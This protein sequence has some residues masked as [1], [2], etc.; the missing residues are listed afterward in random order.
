MKDELKRPL[1][2][3]VTPGLSKLTGDKEETERYFEGIFKYI[4]DNFSYDKHQNTGVFILGTAGMRLLDDK[5]RDIIIE[6][7]T[8]LFKS[9]YNFVKVKTAVISGADEGMFTW[10]T[11]NSRLRLFSAGE[12]MST[13]GIIEMGGASVQVTYR[14]TK[15]LKDTIRRRLGVSE[16]QTKFPELIVKPLL[17]RDKEPYEL[18][19]TTFLGLGGNSARDAY[20][21]LLIS[22]YLRDLNEETSKHLNRNTF[23]MFKSSAKSRRKKSRDIFDPNWNED[24]YDAT[25]T[26]SD[27]QYTKSSPLIIEDPCLPISDAALIVTRPRSMLSALHTGKTIGFQLEPGETNI[28]TI[29]IKGSSDYEKCKANMDEL[30]HLMKKERMNCEDIQDEACSMALLQTPFIPFDQTE[31]IGVGDLHWTNKYLD[32]SEGLFDQHRIQKK[33][34]MICNMSYNE[35][36]ERW[37]KI[38]SEDKSRAQTECFKGV[39]VFVML[40]KGFGLSVD[41]DNFRTME[42]IEGYKLEWTLGAALEKS[43]IIEMAI[44]SRPENPSA[45]ATTA[46][47]TAA[48]TATTTI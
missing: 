34:R 28:F 45:F 26:D 22:R 32:D 42:K 4:D 41:N 7:T 18:V 19:S 43:L 29:H 25:K 1:S 24:D 3:K 37:P 12:N 23:K 20:V 33:A 5:T 15:S 2:K 48:A 6:Q 8:E 46:T 9:K 39:W 47:A 16:A 10:L 35:I 30:L 38:N 11:A 13:A 14:V 17:T 31:F 36:V 44:A 21:D 40:T 27:G